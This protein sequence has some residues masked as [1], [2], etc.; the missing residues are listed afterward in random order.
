MGER[1]W[2]WIPG[3]GVGPFRFGTPV[4]EYEAYLDLKLVRPEGASVTGWGMYEVRGPEKRSGQKM[5]E[6]KRYSVK[7]FLFLKTKT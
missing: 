2:D 3:T 5:E 4:V 7:T 1:G 6:S